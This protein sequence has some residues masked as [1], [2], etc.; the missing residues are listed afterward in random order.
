MKLNRT[1]VNWDRRTRNEI[2]ENWDIIEGITSEIDDVYDDI[3]DRI[4]DVIDYIGGGDGIEEG[5]ITPPKT[6]FLVPDKE[7]NLYGGEF[8]RI[9]LAGPKGAKQVINYNKDARTAVIE[10]EPNTTYSVIREPS[11]IFKIATDTV[12]NRELGQELD[13]SVNIWHGGTAGQSVLNDSFTTGD[14]DVVLYVYYSNQNENT[15]IQVIE[16]VQNE[17]SADDYVFRPNEKLPIYT[18]NEIDTMKYPPDKMLF[19]DKANLFD[20]NFLRL[21]LVGNIETGFTPSERELSRTAKIKIEPNTTYSVIRGEQTSTFKI[22]TD[23]VFHRDSGK[24]EGDVLIHHSFGGPPNYATFTTGPNDV[25]L[26]VQYTNEDENAYVEIV[27]GLRTVTKHDRYGIY[28]LGKDIVVNWEQRDR[29]FK[30]LFISNSF[31]ND[32]IQWVGNIANSY[33]IDV[34]VANA[35][36]SGAN[37]ETQYNNAI[38]DNDV[39]TYIRFDGVNRSEA[40]GMSIKEILRD[41]EW[42]TVIFQQSSSLSSDYSSYQPYLSNL[43]EWTRQNSLNNKLELGLNAI[44]S[45]ADDF[46]GSST[47]LEQWEENM[48]A[49]RQALKDTDMNVL[50]PTGTA[51][52]NARQDEDLNEVGNQLTRDGAH[53]NYGVGRYIAGLT[54]F[55]ILIGCKEGCT[56]DGVEFTPTSDDD[57][58]NDITD[59]VDTS[60]YLSYLAKIMA[61]KAVDNPF[62]IN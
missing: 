41:D 13:G 20:G 35:H 34:T 54:V 40:S 25:A 59:G 1:G 22:G 60:N 24:L 48:E 5:A 26:Y 38:N 61:K 11:S 16:G 58:I 62:Q 52:Q 49:Y 9:G 10:I 43:M 56:I 27:R 37:L 31:G 18:K 32:S 8:E 47:S 3:E 2:N 33:N 55:Y 4:G 30:I 51:I 50:I 21:S 12:L 46:G 45:Y 15:F 53:L 44:W 23:T 14:D 6:N 17:F 57:E 28:Y 42:D 7:I 39:Y 19:L 36:L 29:S